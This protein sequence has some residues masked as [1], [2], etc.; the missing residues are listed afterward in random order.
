VACGEAAARLAA[1]S[2]AQKRIAST[3]FRM[4]QH[5]DAMPVIVAVLVVIVVVVGVLV[6]IRKEKDVK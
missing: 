6:I 4:N 3:A 5:V 1:G 2:G